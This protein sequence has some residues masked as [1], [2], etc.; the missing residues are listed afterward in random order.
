MTG[1]GRWT[2]TGKRLWLRMR[3]G[4]DPV[5]LAAHDSLVSTVSLVAAPVAIVTAPHCSVRKTA[6]PASRS[7]SSVLGAGW[8]KRLWRPTDTIATRGWMA[9]LN[10]AFD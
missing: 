6:A 5:A 7:V 4:E 3:Q 8:P 1:S 2:A 10:A 9:S